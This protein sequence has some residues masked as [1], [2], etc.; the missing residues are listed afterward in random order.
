[1]TNEEKKIE[2]SK[3]NRDNNYGKLTTSHKQQTTGD[4][5]YSITNYQLLMTN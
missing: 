5:Q 3:R 1:M 4:R 2:Y